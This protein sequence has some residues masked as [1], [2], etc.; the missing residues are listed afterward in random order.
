MSNLQAK[1][2]PSA[3]EF[4]VKSVGHSSQGCRSSLVDRTKLTVLKVKHQLDLERIVKVQQELAE[5]QIQSQFDKVELDAMEMVDQVVH[6]NQVKSKSIISQS[7]D[8]Q[9]Y[10]NSIGSQHP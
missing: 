7:A 2:S 6:F 8:L 9:N 5:Q 10:R 3:E 4:D 1:I